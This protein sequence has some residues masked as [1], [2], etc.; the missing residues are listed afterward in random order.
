MTDTSTEAV[1]KWLSQQGLILTDPP[2]EAEASKLVHAL[3]KERDELK[4]QQEKTTDRLNLTQAKLDSLLTSSWREGEP[5]KVSGSEWF[6]AETEWKARVVLRRL[7][8]DNSYDYMTAEETY[9]TSERAKI[10]KWMQFPDSHFLPPDCLSKRVAELKAMVG[11]IGQLAWWNPSKQNNYTH[12]AKTIF[13]TYYVG[14]C[15]GRH[16][17]WIELFHESGRIEQWEGEVRGSLFQAKMD[18]QRH[19]EARIRSAFVTPPQDAI[20]K[21]VKA[22][23]DAERYQWLRSRNID[24]VHRGGVF[25][26][27]TPDNYVLNGEDLDRHIDVAIR[28]RKET[29]S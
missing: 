24:T 3:L 9:V 12:G 23:R 26:G 22:E 21:A 19:Y 4:A 20:A 2:K 6:I 1:D 18:A 7:D 5:D 10:V 14:I 11:V 15:G 13:G 16:Y 25:A 29:Q 28:K 17:A 27:V 8:D